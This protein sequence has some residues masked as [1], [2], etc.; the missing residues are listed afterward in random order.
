MT[1][2]GAATVPALSAKG[3]LGDDLFA[4]RREEDAVAAAQGSDDLPPMPADA[5]GV[6]QSHDG[7]VHGHPAVPPL[8]FPDGTGCPKRTRLGHN[9]RMSKNDGAHAALPVLAPRGDFDAQNTGPLTAEIRE[10]VSRSPGVVLDLSD[11]TF[12]DSSFLNLLLSAHQETDLR[13]AQVPAGIERL[14]SLTGTESVL[15]IYGTVEEAQATVR[16]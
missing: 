2:N 6:R 5:R 1:G 9:R 15:R 8:R 11:V 12:G 4:V 14:L 13:I 16:T 3:H 7:L 10:T